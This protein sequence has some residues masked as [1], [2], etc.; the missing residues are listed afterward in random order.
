VQVVGE[1]DV[2]T[3]PQLEQTLRE[4]RAQL[5]VLDLRELAHGYMDA[6]DPVR[7]LVRLPDEEGSP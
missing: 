6:V 1:L 2:E 5:V 7:A 4:P 3:T